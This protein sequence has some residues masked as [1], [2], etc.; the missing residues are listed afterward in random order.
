MKRSLTRKRAHDLPFARPDIDEDD[1]AAVV[2]AMRSGW[3]TTGPR[4]R[5]FEAAFAQYLGVRHAVALNSAASGRVRQV[6]L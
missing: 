3:V 6:S 1:I 5:E 4:V 2:D